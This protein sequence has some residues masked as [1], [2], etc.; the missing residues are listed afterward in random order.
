MGLASAPSVPG[1]KLAPHAPVKG[2]GAARPVSPAFPDY[3]HTPARH[4]DP[5]PATGEAAAV[6]QQARAGL[7]DGLRDAVLAF[8]AAPLAP[9]VLL[10]AA[11]FL[12][13]APAGIW[14]RQ[15]RYARVQGLPTT[16]L[17]VRGPAGEQRGWSG[18]VVTAGERRAAAQLA[19]ATRLV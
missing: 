19:L 7:R 4:S 18:W 2:V 16:A 13:L 12:F 5:F 14:R 6:L 1:E 9:L 17:V 15:A 8:T 11:A 10:V 3:P